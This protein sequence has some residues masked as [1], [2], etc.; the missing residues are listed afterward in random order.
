MKYLTGKKLLIVL[1]VVVTVLNLASLSAIV[2]LTYFRD[3][4]ERVVRTHREEFSRRD[5]RP[6]NKETRRFF[7][8]VRSNFVLQVRPRT[9]ELRQTQSLIMEELIKDHPDQAR[10]DSLAEASGQLHATIKKEMA[11]LFLK[12]NQKAT[13][14][15]KQHLEH[16]YRH[17]MMENRPGPP[18]ERGKGKRQGRNLRHAPQEICD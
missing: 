13:P 12:M 14:E 6:L 4:S 18:H 10:L 16:F 17:F 15:Q 5:R 11:S 8:E 7:D 2:Y 3:S 1:I 9:R